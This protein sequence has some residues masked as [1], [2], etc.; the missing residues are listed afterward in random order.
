M[1]THNIRVAVPVV[2]SARVIQCEGLFDVPGA[3]TSSR[4]WR[5]ELP[6]EEREWEIGLIVGPSGSGKSTLARHLWPQVERKNEWDT[7]RSILDAFPKGMPIA[8]ITGLLSSVGLGTVPSWLKPHRVLSV[9]EMFRADVALS[10]TRDDDPVVFD[11]FTSVVDRQVGKVASH[12]IAK[13]ARR[14][15]QRLVAVTCHYDV[16]P[17]LNPDWVIQMETQQFTWRSKQPRPEVRVDVAPIS[18]KAWEYFK[19]Y[20][21][22]T[23]KLP[24]GM[25]G[26][27]GGWIEDRCVT[28][29]YVCRFPH[30]SCRD[31]VRVRRQVVLP[32]WQGLG[33]GPRMEE[34]LGRK[35]IALGNRVRSVA[36]HPGMV[37]H[38]RNSPD[39]VYVAHQPRRT[40]TG[41]KSVQGRHHQDPRQTTLRTYEFRPKS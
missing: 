29:A 33:I 19:F 1:S 10:L 9:G 40:T 34:Y 4:E 38:Y 36:A 39:W 13:A 5:I 16:E 30:P 24:G 31:I 23:A 25:I 18:P 14:R 7:D 41:P 21:Y 32:D 15:K 22:L 6:L 2:R 17:W 28:F 27:Y 20:H 12:A 37:N 8:E 35:Y 11:E 26:C 3:S